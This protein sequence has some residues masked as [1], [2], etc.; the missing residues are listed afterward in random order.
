MNF[1]NFAWA[2]EEVASG[3]SLSPLKMFGLDL[4]LFIAQVINFLVVLIVLWRWA[5][6]P[7]V[8]KMNERT[9][10]IEQGLK[11][12][13]AAARDRE[14]AQRL[15]TEANIQAKKE[16]AQILEEARQR[17]EAE[18]QKIVTE[19]REKAEN[20]VEQARKQIYQEKEKMIR[21]AR[22]EVGELVIAATKR[23]LGEVVTPEID[24]K[25]VEDV[26]KTLKN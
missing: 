16:A 1:I 9:A 14:A 5:Y 6:R 2:A 15:K 11:D 22:A 18:R 12:A 19:T 17:A 4:K 20:I 13:A 25:L 24:K 23:V 3:A 26:L 8:R 7:L 21:Q 10:R